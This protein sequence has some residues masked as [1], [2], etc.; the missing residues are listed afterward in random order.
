MTTTI[1]TDEAGR[2]LPSQPRREDYATFAEYAMAF[3]EWK[4]APVRVA[5]RAFTEAFSVAM[6][7]PVTCLRSCCSDGPPRAMSYRG[8]VAAED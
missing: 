7:H 3:Y 6:A 2:P 4:D 8:H 1:L 5:Y